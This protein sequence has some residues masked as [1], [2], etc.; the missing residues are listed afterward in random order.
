MS[1]DLT[2]DPVSINMDM[3]IGVRVLKPVKYTRRVEPVGFLGWQWVIECEYSKL[4]SGRFFTRT[5]A[6]RDLARY[7]T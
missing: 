1:S 2:K 3:V 4:T 6:E 5:E 7:P